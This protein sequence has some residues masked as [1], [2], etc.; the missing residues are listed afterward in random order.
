MAII[1]VF[2]NQ[3]SPYILDDVLNRLPL[4]GFSLGIAVA[5]IMVIYVVYKSYEKHK[6][7]FKSSIIAN[8]FVIEQKDNITKWI[9]N[10]EKRIRRNNIKI[11]AKRYIVISIFVFIAVFIFGINAFRNVTASVLFA[12]VFLVIPEYVISLYEDSV[13]KKI[14][15]QLIAAIR[16]YMAEFMQKKPMQKI[17]S[18]LSTKLQNPVGKYFSDAYYEMITGVSTDVVLSR[19][20][21]KFSSNYGKI[22]IQLIHQTQKDSNVINLFPELLVK[23]ENYIELTRN[24]KISLAGDRIQALI[25]SLLPIPAYFAMAKIFPETRIFVR[26]TP[27]GRLIITF[28]FL[29][30][31]IFIVIDRFIRRVE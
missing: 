19:L 31:F 3:I 11:K 26:E 17:F 30:I 16:L 23:I 20:T 13:E 9:E 7:R 18:S 22:F 24:N 8:K 15:D 12:A 27:Y 29:S 21:S 10:T 5:I 14:E 4:I 25:M 2:K 1:K 6:D 28:S